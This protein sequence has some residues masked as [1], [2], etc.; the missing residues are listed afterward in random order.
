VFDWRGSNPPAFL[1]GWLGRYRSY[2][3]ALVAT[4]FH[5]PRH[6][7]EFGHHVFAVVSEPIHAVENTVNLCRTFFAVS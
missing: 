3:R 5:P 2:C 4:E 6:L 7:G 1:F